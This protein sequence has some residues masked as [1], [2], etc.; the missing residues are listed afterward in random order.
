MSIQENDP[1]TLQ[2]LDEIDREWVKLWLK[3]TGKKTA[4]RHKFTTFVYQEEELCSQN[5]RK[6]PIFC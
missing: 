2:I 4:N 3:A 5:L 1:D 6:K